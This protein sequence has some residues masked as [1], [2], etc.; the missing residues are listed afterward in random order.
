MKRFSTGLTMI[1][2]LATIG[3]PTA[4][5]AERE[6]ALLCD[7]QIALPSNVQLVIQ[8]GQ[9][10]QVRKAYTIPGHNLPYRID[11]V[12]TCAYNASRTNRVSEIQA[13]AEQAGE[14]IRNFHPATMPAG[15]QYAL[16]SRLRVIEGRRIQTVE[17]FFATRDLQYHFYAIPSEE[18]YPGIDRMNAMPVEQ[19]INELHAVIT[20]S[21]FIRP[22]EVTITEARYRSRLYI[23]V[24]GSIFAI[25]ILLTLMLRFYI[26][27]N[28]RAKS[29]KIKRD[30]NQEARTS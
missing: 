14:L 23:T 28:K 11:W 2:V 29:L 26:R 25:L 17:S 18:Q 13:E 15:I 22:P 21:E 1:L 8:Q 30:E 10:I 9:L 24:G 4:L 20:E 16:Y 27:R 3:R 12:F 19:L 7:Y 6:A 5:R